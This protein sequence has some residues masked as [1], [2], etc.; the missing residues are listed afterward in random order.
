MQR[1]REISPVA[2]RL[3][4]PL[5][6]RDFAPQNQQPRGVSKDRLRQM[7]SHDSNATRHQAQRSVPGP[8][9]PG[10][11]QAS[12][13]QASDQSAKVD[14]RSHPTVEELPAHQVAP[15][16]ADYFRARHP[17]ETTKGHVH[18]ADE[19]LATAP[20]PPAR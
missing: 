15:A 19:D 11:I 16:A 18:L 4:M 14:C 6:E 1:A 20:N 13:D 17:P 10:N 2:R 7:K 9:G 5:P 12:T 3:L 8:F